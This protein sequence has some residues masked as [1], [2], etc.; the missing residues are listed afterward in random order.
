MGLPSKL[1]KQIAFNTKPKIEE[2]ILIIT[3]KS[4]DKEPVSQSL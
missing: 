1:S 3:K 4:T 2:H